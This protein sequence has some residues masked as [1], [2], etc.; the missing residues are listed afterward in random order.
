[1]SSSGRTFGYK[2]AA[3]LLLMAQETRF[4]II[5]AIVAHPDG[6]PSLVELDIVLDEH[7]STI[8]EHVQSLISSDIVARYEYT[9]EDHPQNL[10]RVFY[11]LTPTGYSIVTQSSAFDDISA[12]RDANSHADDIA[13]YVSL[14]RPDNALSIHDLE[15]Y[16]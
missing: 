12:I 16:A 10:P 9:G 1:M 3:K 7:K 2:R 14:D 11:G 15:Q 5:N 8:Y 13:E 6:L 4:G